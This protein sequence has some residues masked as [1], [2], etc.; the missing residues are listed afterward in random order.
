[1]RRLIAFL[2]ATFFFGS[3][4]A[5]PVSYQFRAFIGP[6]V[7]ATSAKLPAALTPNTD[8]I[9]TLVLD[10]ARTAEQMDSIV[11]LR[12]TKTDGTVIFDTASHQVFSNIEIRFDRG[13]ETATIF[14]YTTT[15]AGTNL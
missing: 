1:M 9:G 7:T 4:L 3:A 2:L 10:P 15:S 14:G 8:V 6:R 12:L 5:V 11:S 13:V